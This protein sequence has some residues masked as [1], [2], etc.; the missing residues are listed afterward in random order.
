MKNKYIFILTVTVITSLLLS[1]ASEGLKSLKL[2]N[3]ELD[4]LEFHSVQ[5]IHYLSEVEKR[6]YSDR[7]NF[8]GD[9]DFVQDNQS[10]SSKGVLRGLHFQNPPYAQGKLVRVIKG[11]VVDVAV[12]IRKD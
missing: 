6:V 9:I 10:L 4:T 3:I 11:V 8:L 7:A 5:H 1:I 12:D 2:K